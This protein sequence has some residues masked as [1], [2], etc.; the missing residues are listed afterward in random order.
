MKTVAEFIKELQALEQDKP[1]WVRYDSCYAIVPEVE[2][3]DG[4]STDEIKA[5]DY[6]INAW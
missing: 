4:E 6:E 2:I 3:S 5:G 1:I